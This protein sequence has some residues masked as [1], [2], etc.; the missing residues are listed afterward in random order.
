MTEKQREAKARAA[1]AR[2]EANIAWFSDL[3]EES[4]ARV[5]QLVNALVLAGKTPANALELARCLML[6]HTPM[7]KRFETE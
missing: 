7:L 5:R 4:K 1:K 2:A 6:G 3:S